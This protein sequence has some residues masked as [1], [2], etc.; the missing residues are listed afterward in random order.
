MCHTLQY[1]IKGITLCYWLKW[2]SQ[3]RKWLIIGFIGLISTGCATLIPGLPSDGNITETP[4]PSGSDINSTAQPSPTEAPTSPPPT[5]TPLQPAV[6]LDFPAAGQLA[7]V[8]LDGSITVLRAGEEPLSV[9]GDSSS[10]DIQ[11]FYRDPTWSPTGWLSYVQVERDADGVM[12]DVVAVRPGQNEPQTIFNTTQA[13]YIY[14]YWSPVPCSDGPDCGQ[15]AYLMNDVTG[16][17][18]HLAQV[19]S[20]TASDIIAGEGR[21][22]YYSWSPDGTSMLWRRDAAELE[23]YD[24]LNNMI[25][26]TLPDQPGLFSAPAWSPVDERLLFARVEDDL[27]YMTIAD[28]DERTEFETALP[29]F[30]YFNWSPDGQKIAFV[31]GELPFPK[32]S[33]ASADG[34]AELEV[35]NLENI[36]AFFWSPDST[37]LAVVSFEEVR[38]SPL[39]RGD[40]RARPTRQTGKPALIWHVVDAETGQ[41]TR[42]TPFLP[43][44]EEFYLLQFFDQFAQSH[45]VWSPDSRF[46]VFAG[47]TPADSEPTINLID[48]FEPEA[49]PIK[50]MTGV[51][52]I[53][54]YT[55]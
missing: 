43:T 2:Q 17:K 31:N 28:G 53:F 1:T 55:D 36:V 27:N 25:T 8:G 45:R 9:T 3:M 4:E 22:L 19:Y 12:L 16:I 20:E 44:G 24:V 23:I 34:I 10:P 29:G 49:A 54:S 7:V 42:L 50:L 14:G 51:Q 40:V 13:N 15:F 48:T 35:P 32:L 33:I 21:S 46:I 38:E 41:E 37:R 26:E 47:V 6:D 30:V 18:L 5:P 11:R 39:D 52:A